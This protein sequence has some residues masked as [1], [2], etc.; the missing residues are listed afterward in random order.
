M[1]SAPGE[2]LARW[3]AVVGKAGGR[4]WRDN[5]WSS[6]GAADSGIYKAG[7]SISGQRGDNYGAFWDVWTSDAEKTDYFFFYVSGAAFGATDWEGG[8][9]EPRVG[10]P[11][12]HGSHGLKPCRATLQWYLAS[13][14]H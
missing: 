1:I 6:Y 13:T 12:V 5:T 2:T 14:S 8:S 7:S 11:A 4:A 10:A 9:S 3:D